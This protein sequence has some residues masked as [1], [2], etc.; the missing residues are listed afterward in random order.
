MLFPRGTYVASRRWAFWV[1]GLAAS[2]YVRPAMRKRIYR[3]L[4]LRISPEAWEIGARCYFH[5]SDV[6]IG[7]RTIIND[8][9][10]FENVGTLTIGSGVGISVG[11]TVL[12]SMHEIGPSSQRNGEWS[13]RPV[14]IEDG[15][16]IGARAL[17]YPG[18]TIGRGAIVAPGAVVTRD[19]EPDHLYGGV[20]AKVIRRLD[21]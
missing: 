10:Y 20:P 4:G 5:S 2:P 17:I 6:S 14:R 19:C 11:V 9:C 21:G 13:Y 7:P 18:V 8:L 1:N 16:W 3:R 12:T 15:A